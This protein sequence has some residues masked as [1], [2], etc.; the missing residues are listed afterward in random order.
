MTHSPLRRAAHSIGLALALA[1]TAPAVAMAD[2]VTFTDVVGRTVHLEAPAQRVILGDGRTLL[3][4]AVLHPDPVSIL[5]GWPDQLR[6][7]DPDTYA[8]FQDAFPGLEDVPHVS[9]GSAA[10]FSVERALAL[11]PDAVIFSGG[12]S[13][14]ADA[15]EVIAQLEAAGVAVAFIDFGASPMDNTIPSLAVLGAVLGRQAE[16]EA[17]SALVRDRMDRI[18]T[19]LAA[20]PDLSRPA[21]FM[22]MHAVGWD[23][24]YSP[25]SG[26]LGQLIEAAGG[27]NIGA[28][29]LPSPT[30]QLSW[31]YVL[32]RNPDV[33][34][35]TGG[36]HQRDNGGLVLGTGIALD[37]A[38]ERLTAIASHRDIAPLA[39]TR[40]GRIHGLWHHFYVSPLNVVVLELLAQWSHPELFA[41]LDPAAT[42]AEI[43]E[44]YLAVPLVGTYWV[45]LP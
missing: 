37:E 7:A 14:S 43:N 25:G 45:E 42:L 27:E 8:L 29:V 34:I 36:P 19:R 41:D 30:G 13:P 1:L 20:H 24:C 22:H 40:A 3:A 2:P 16:A 31:E 28:A 21:V 44:T 17:F 33:Y 9:A 10:S 39:A 23:C 32:S 12:H 11:R 18:A 15:H 26:N 35:A 5:A 6:R 38:A 4:L